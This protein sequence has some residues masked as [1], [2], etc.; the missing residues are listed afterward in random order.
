M[1]LEHIRSQFPILARPLAKGVRLAY[2]DTASTAQ[3]PQC[4]IDKESEI[5]ETCYANAYRGVYRFGELIDEQL[6]AARARVANF[7]GAESPDEVIFTGGTTMSLNLVAQSWGRAFLNA[8]DEILLNE[9]EHHANLV[10]WQMVAKERRAVLKFIPLTSD[11][12]LDLTRLDEVLTPRCK[13]VAVTGMSNMLGTINPVAELAARAHA[14]G[15][16]IVVDG[17][18]SVPHL[19]VHVR[20]AGIDFLAFSG[21]KIYG[22]SGVGILYGRKELLAAM[23][24]FLGGGHMIDRVYTTHATWAESPAKF[25]AG[26][27]PIAQAIALGT[28]IEWVEQ[29]GLHVAH[30]YEQGLTQRAWDALLQIPGMHIYGPPPT[31]RGGIL[32]FTI[33]RAH[34][35]D[36]AQLL[37][38]KGVFVRHGHHCTMPLH[39]KLGV[40]ATVRA[41]FGVY[42]NDED[43]DQLIQAIHFARQKLRLV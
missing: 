28:A 38:R 5:Y 11:G 31:Q 40:S 34:P 9:M 35:E 37:D 18:Q 23:P 33:D 2:F 41:S 32:S 27:P 43:L 42:T 24:P 16:V 21:H 4:V 22:P 29:I 6:E 17:A 19:P 30:E 20:E 39:D 15:A 26:T 7:I 3:K 13:V 1:S 14:V 25:E 12:Q 36:L 8:G 10:P